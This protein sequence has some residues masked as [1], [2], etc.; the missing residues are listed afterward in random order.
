MRFENKRC[1][2]FGRKK[3][4]IKKKRKR[5]RKSK[6]PKK[7]RKIKGKCSRLGVLNATNKAKVVGLYR[8]GNSNTEW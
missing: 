2:G 7:K 3:K 6:R 5:R 1:K 8:A 4:G